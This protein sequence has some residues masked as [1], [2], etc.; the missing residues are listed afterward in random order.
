[1]MILPNK[2]FGKNKKIWDGGIYLSN[3]FLKINEFWADKSTWN[4]IEDNSC[5]PH[6]WDC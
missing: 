4:F 6:A 5:R 1:M 2:Y 3:R